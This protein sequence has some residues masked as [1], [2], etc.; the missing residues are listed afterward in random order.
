MAGSGIIDKKLIVRERKRCV[1]RK[2][3]QYCARKGNNNKGCSRCFD[4]V[5][6]DDDGDINENEYSCQ[7]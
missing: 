5:L 3:N 6:P 1:L 4:P 7:K 2:K